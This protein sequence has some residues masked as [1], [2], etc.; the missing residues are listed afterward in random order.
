MKQ[1]KTKSFTLIE[2]IMVI[3]ILAI[4]AS[5]AIP[6]FVDLSA[7]ANQ[8][9]EDGVVAGIVTGLT[10]YYAM[11]LSYPPTLGNAPVGSCSDASPCFTNVLG[12]GGITGDWTKTSA[13]TYRGPTGSNY[14]YDSVNGEFRK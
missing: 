2:L 12:Q 8:A 3:V 14:T 7:S 11:N 1:I 9:A 6:R 5:I 4:I 10:S 13:V